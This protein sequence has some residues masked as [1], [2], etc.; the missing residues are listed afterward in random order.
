ME[1][2]I[3][4]C[5][6]GLPTPDIMGRQSGGG[7]TVGTAVLPI[8][9]IIGIAV[10]GSA[11]LFGILTV[12][13]MHYIRSR[14]KV[15]NGGRDLDLID[16]DEE[17]ILNALRSTYPSES[18]LVS[19][20]P[21]RP[22]NAGLELLPK[23][24]TEI[25][26]CGPP[27]YKP[28]RVPPA[29]AFDITGLRDS[30]P[31]VSLV[32]SASTVPLSVNK[33]PVIKSGNTHSRSS[34][35]AF[36][37]SID[38]ELSWPQRVLSR[39]SSY[40]RCL[41]GI[42][43][44]WS[45]HS[46]KS[47]VTSL[48]RP[49][50]SRKSVSENQLT[51]ILRSTSQRLKEAQLRPLSRS[52]SV[53]SQVS[54]APPT[55]QPPSPLGDQ[56]GESREALIV[57]DDVSLIDSVRSSVLNSVSQTPSPH[58]GE[59]NMVNKIERDDKKEVSPAISEISQCYSLCPS[60][61]PDLLIPSTLTSLSKRGA[62][63]DQRYEMKILSTDGTS[64]NIHKEDGNS[65]LAGGS[66]ITTHDT[67]SSIQIDSA[68]N[69]FVSS[70]PRAKLPPKSRPVKGPRPLIKRQSIGE[71][72]PNSK[73]RETVHSPLRVVSGNQKS[74]SKSTLPSIVLSGATKENPFPWSPQHLPLLLSSP[75]QKPMGIKLKGHRRRRTVRLSHLSR[76]VN[77]AVVSGEPE[78]GPSP[79]CKDNTAGTQK[80][81]LISPA[82]LVTTSTD[83]NYG[84]I[85]SPRPPA[86]SIFQPFLTMPSSRAPTDSK[87]PPD[88]S[89]SAT[90]SFYDYYSSSGAMPSDHLGIPEPSQ[91]PAPSTKKSRRRGYNFSAEII[92]DRDID[93][94]EATTPNFQTDGY[95]SPPKS[96]PAES[97]SLEISTD[98]TAVPNFTSH[99]NGPASKP[100]S[101]INDSVAASVSLLRRMNSQVSTYST[102]SFLSE[103]SNGSPTIPALRGGGL[104]PMKR[105]SESTMNYLNIGPKTPSPI[106]KGEQA[107]FSGISGKRRD[108]HQSFVFEDGLERCD[109]LG[110]IMP[111]LED[112]PAKMPFL[113]PLRSMSCHGDW[114][115]KSPDFLSTSS[116]W[117]SPPRRKKAPAAQLRPV[118]STPLPQELCNS[119]NEPLSPLRL[120]PRDST[121]A[122]RYHDHCFK[123]STC[124]EPLG[125][126]F[127]IDKKS[128]CKQHYY[129]RVN[130]ICNVDGSPNKKIGSDR[131]NDRWSEVMTTPVKKSRH[132]I[133]FEMSSPHDGSPKSMGKLRTSWEFYDEMG[134][135]K[136]SPEGGNNADSF[137]FGPTDDL[138]MG[139]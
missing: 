82:E 44:R 117:P 62:W 74:P 46:A 101:V 129:D 111:I 72:S 61:T 17:D 116:K 121:I 68:S 55:V 5:G 26:P 136:C 100:P 37:L 104:S 64:T 132:G 124:S 106:S 29:D 77:V 88:G 22:F 57:T 139:T 86:V 67:H 135:L 54:G 1:V 76:P 60:K 123:C 52:L 70:D 94:L 89:Y 53:V 24:W 15:E 80:S 93:L 43:L 83:L 138:I 33:R 35:S 69:P 115:V 51:S 108:Y 40:T 27:L 38:N 126:A 113:E 120:N 112:S 125:T 91:S 39:S 3:Q 4:T 105:G 65:M 133:Q 118:S 98:V 97:S 31:L 134:F 103:H 137:G 41:D 56:R 12:T 114:P 6:D 122:S 66:T 87:V 109:G 45:G 25:P 34:Y 78:N 59:L 23:E 2:S 79:H 63:S 30:W 107:R 73:G 18:G 49:S 21:Q 19:K 42:P 75:G 110:L 14:Y 9:A 20:I 95:L 85:S 48:K 7:V 84:N 50:S 131:S 32:D 128:Y 71:Q 13:I 127:P 16:G 81:Q 99:F 92:R 11:I 102:G 96:A 58:K 119:C 8:G 47:S 10:A 28:K 130:E 36:P 90:M